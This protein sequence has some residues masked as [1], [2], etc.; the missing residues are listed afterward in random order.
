MDEKEYEK[1]NYRMYNN[2]SKAIKKKQKLNEKYKKE[3]S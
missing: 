3:E 2:K 1:Q